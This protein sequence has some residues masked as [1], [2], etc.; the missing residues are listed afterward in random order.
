MITR[1]EWQKF[2]DS[3]YNSMFTWT[4]RIKFSRGYYRYESL[5]L[6]NIFEFAQGWRTINT[7]SN[8]AGKRDKDYLYRFGTELKHQNIETL[9]KYIK[10]HKRDLLRKR[11]IALSSKLKTEKLNK[12]LKGKHL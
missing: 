4:K 6:T 2:T 5:D 1:T 9:L 7:Y 8:L 10:I 12:L 3:I 11:R